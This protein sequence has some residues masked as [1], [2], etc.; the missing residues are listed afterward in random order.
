MNYP[1]AR[2]IKCNWAKVFLTNQNKKIYLR[3]SLLF[4]KNMFAILHSKLQ[5]IDLQDKVTNWILRICFNFYIIFLQGQQIQKQIVFVPPIS[6]FDR[7]QGIQAPLLFSISSGNS[8]DIDPLGRTTVQS[9]WSPF[10]HIL[11]MH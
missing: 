6:A 5:V 2:S 3:N 11:S 7:D 8:D 4:L 9:G 10:S 1:V